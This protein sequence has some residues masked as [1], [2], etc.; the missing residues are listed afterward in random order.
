MACKGHPWLWMGI[1]MDPMHPWA[2]PACAPVPVLLC[3]C[4]LLVPLRLCPWLGSWLGALCWPLVWHFSAALC[5]ECE[6]KS[7]CRKT[8]LQGG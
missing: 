3:L 6:G 2:T 1:I 4:P 5:L 8:F 7:L